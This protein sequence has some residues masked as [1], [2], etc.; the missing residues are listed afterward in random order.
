M[1]P[2]LCFLLCIII[3]IDIMIMIM[4]RITMTA[5]NAVSLDFHSSELAWLDP[6]VKD[7]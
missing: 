7:I 2:E 4:I 6:S 5:T 1:I 3:T